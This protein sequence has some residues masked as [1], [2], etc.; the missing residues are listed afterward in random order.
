MCQALCQALA[1]TSVSK[2]P[3]DRYRKTDETGCHLQLGGCCGGVLHWD[4]FQ[5]GLA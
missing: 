4:T 5:W 3:R 1:V 2:N